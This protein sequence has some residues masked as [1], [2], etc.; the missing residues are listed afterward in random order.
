MA[1]ENM[2]DVHDHIRGC[3]AR[4]VVIENLVAAWILAGILPARPV[5]LPTS[6]SKPSEG[7]KSP[8]PAETPQNTVS[9]PATA[10]LGDADA[11][12]DRSVI[13]GLKRICAFFSGNINWA[14]TSVVQA[15]D[16]IQ[17]LRQQLN[18]AL[19][20]VKV[21]TADLE[22]SKKID[23]G[24]SAYEHLDH[25][26]GA[27]A[28]LAADHGSACSDVTAVRRAIDH[29]RSLREQLKAK[30]APVNLSEGDKE[31]IGRLEKAGEQVK[32][33]GYAEH[34]YSIQLAIC[35]LTALRRDLDNR[36]KQ[37]EWLQGRNVA[38]VN[39]LDDVR[40]RINKFEEESKAQRESE[41]E[42]K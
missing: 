14:R 37:I 22:Q 3:E 2:Q 1:I 36:F 35:Y 18:R 34:E 41:K 39:A 17:W 31:I 42:N 29:I 38:I 10:S 20:R 5:N 9:A 4:L 28:T 23:A 12:A 30:S 26:R 32:A 33:D 11:A 16:Y 21:L 25:L 15:I 13:D 19:E 8:Q 27:A 24:D 7:S 6:D 40:N